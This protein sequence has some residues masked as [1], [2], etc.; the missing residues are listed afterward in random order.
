MS[1]NEEA[2]SF[3]DWEKERKKKEEEEDQARKKAKKEEEE[4]RKAERQ[5]AK[6]AAKKND[7]VVDDDDELTEK[8]L[9]MMR[10]YKKTK[11]G[12]TTSYFTREVS[13][14]EKA[15]LQQAAGPK[16]IGS[17]AATSSAATTPT[18]SSAPTPTPVNNAQESSATGAAAA[19]AWNQAGTWEEKD[20][21]AW[22]TSCLKKHLTAAAVPGIYSAKVKE[23]KD[24]SGDAS[25]VLTR[26]KKRYVFDYHLTLKFDVVHVREAGVNA[27]EIDENEA[28]EVTAAAPTETVVAT[29]T[30]KLPDISS[31]VTIDELEIEPSSGWKKKPSDAHTA[32]VME[33]RSRLVEEVRQ[34]VSS[35]V[36]EFNAQY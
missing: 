28:D 9:A 26:G 34:Q 2:I 16:L 17:A 13:E 23:V 11:D 25:V 20:T 24:C 30:L 31:T 32:G 14:E 27:D 1:H 22:C 36:S 15:L 10:G 3:E 21:T 8:E 6:A 18:A 29:G 5:A 12:R 35:F 4:R 7:V 33:C 19:S